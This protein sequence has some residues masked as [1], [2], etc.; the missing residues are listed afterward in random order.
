MPS[1]KGKKPGKSPRKETQPHATLSESA[2]SP[3]LDTAQPN[4]RQ[5]TAQSDAVRARAGKH[6]RPADDIDPGHS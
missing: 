1:P 5:P 2:L 6:G 4:T 3:T